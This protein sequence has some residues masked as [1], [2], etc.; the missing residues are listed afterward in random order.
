M[1]TRRSKIRRG[2]EGMTMI[3]LVIAMVVLAIGL[4][5][6]MIMISG[7]I[8]SNNRNKTDTT[9]T[10]LSE[11]IME[12]IIAAGVGATATFTMSDCSGATNSILIDPTGSTAGRGAA[13]DAT[14]G[15]ISFTTAASPTS[16]YT[17]TYV[18]CGVNGSQA[19][20]DV[21]W[22]VVNTQAS[23]TAV[24]AKMVTVSAR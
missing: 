6:T 10:T 21:R 23:G 2:E 15:N 7:S 8:T 11:A 19:T 14:T 12:R 16:G 24:Y 1:F 13:V 17:A 4:G 20:Y 9:A 18:T 3:E 22:R 5:G